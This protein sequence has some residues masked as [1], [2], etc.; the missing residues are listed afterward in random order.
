[1]TPAAHLGAKTSAP[2]RS[3]NAIIV[4]NTHRKRHTHEEVSGNEIGKVEAVCSSNNVKRTAP[5]LQPGHAIMA[6]VTLTNTQADYHAPTCLM[7]QPFH[8]LHTMNHIQPC[9]YGSTGV[10]SG[11]MP[12]M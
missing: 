6:A 5:L 2:A 11:H 10:M 9:T 4:E 7:S 1:M 12:H 3:K 8:V